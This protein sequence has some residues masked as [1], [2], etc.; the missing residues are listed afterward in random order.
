MCEQEAAVMKQYANL[1]HTDSANH[2]DLTDENHAS[3]FK[4]HIDTLK[5]K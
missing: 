1:S 5:G 2:R 4:T 3:E